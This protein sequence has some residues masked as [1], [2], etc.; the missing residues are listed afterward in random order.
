MKR[1]AKNV[2]AYFARLRRARPHDFPKAGR[3]VLCPP[4][5]R[6]Y[7]ILD[8][9]GRVAHVGRTTRARA[10]LLQRL[11]SRLAGRSSFVI[12]FVKRRPSRLRKGYSYAWVEIPNPRT[13][14]LVKAYATGILCPRHI[15]TS[16]AGAQPAHQ[17]VASGRPLR[18]E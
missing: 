7:L 17:A 3:R 8:P 6:V 10:G 15:G 13:R 16:E 18:E 9:S 4:R 5:H 14:A 1:E 12:L 11:R 2:R